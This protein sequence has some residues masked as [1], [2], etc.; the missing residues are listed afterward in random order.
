MK[1][2]DLKTSLFAIVVAFAPITASSNSERVIRLEPAT[3]FRGPNPSLP[4]VDTPEAA[5]AQWTDWYAPHCVSTVPQVEGFCTF[6]PLQPDFQSGS[7]NGIPARYLFTFTHVSIDYRVSPPSTSFV[8]NWTQVQ[9]FHRCQ[10]GFAF[11][12]FPPYVVAQSAYCHKALPFIE[13]ADCPRTNNPILVSNGIKIVVE[14]DYVDPRRKLAVE[15]I[16]RSDYGGFNFVVDRQIIDYSSDGPR[17]TVVQAVVER[18]PG[19]YLSRS[20]RVFGAGADLIRR[21][22][23]DE[24]QLWAPSNDV[25]AVGFIQV[26]G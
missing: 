4:Q 8:T 23:P 13:P 6:G 15:R 18:N 1:A 9:S 24:V 2:H 5:H 25:R 12:N 11:I 21:G 14:N 22:K 17:A 16:Y 26:G 19:E 3:F 7:I 10:V 20:F